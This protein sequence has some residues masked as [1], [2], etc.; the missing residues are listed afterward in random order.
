MKKGPNTV[1]KLALH[2]GGIVI[3]DGNS[4][5]HNV[6]DLDKAGEGEIA[7]VE[8]EKFVDI[9]K[10]SPSLE[11]FL[12]HIHSSGSDFFSVFDTAD[13]TFKVAGSD[14][15]PPLWGFATAIE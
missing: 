2:V 5:I 10:E 8:D 13:G 9:A 7:Y 15:P 1:A 11:D 14:N 6:A 4:L 3:G 12:G